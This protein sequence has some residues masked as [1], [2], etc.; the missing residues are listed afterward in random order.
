M[1]RRRSRRGTADDTSAVVVCPYCSEE[2][3][4]YVD[5]DT[6]GSFVQDCE[7]CC[8]PW[9]LSVERDEDGAL[10]VGVMRAQ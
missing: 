5:P 7:V 3:E 6:A 8:H 2:V 1:P 9:Q 10:H 4:I